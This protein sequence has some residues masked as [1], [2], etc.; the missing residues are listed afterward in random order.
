MVE[1][2]M[3]DV[4]KSRPLFLSSYHPFL[5][6][7]ASL[8]HHFERVDNILHANDLDAIIIFKPI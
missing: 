4:P 1:D 7:R 8:K 5:D 2:E 6:H 3:M